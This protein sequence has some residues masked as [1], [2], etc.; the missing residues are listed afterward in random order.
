LAG[1]A[2]GERAEG[3]VD[4]SLP[5]PPSYAAVCPPATTTAA[6]AERKPVRIHAGLATG[7]VPCD[8]REDV[9]EGRRGEGRGAAA[10]DLIDF[11][12]PEGA[13]VLDVLERHVV[14]R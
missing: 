11:T 2:G 14:K 6:A 1:G 9:Q 5:P 7:A 13:A 10:A 3:Y 8:L 4:V 12:T